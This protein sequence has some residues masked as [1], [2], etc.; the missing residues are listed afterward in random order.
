MTYQWPHINVGEKHGKDI[1][2]AVKQIG[3]GTHVTW[4]G[5]SQEGTSMSWSF[6]FKGS[7]NSNS[8]RNNKPPTW[9]LGHSKCHFYPKK[10]GFGGSFQ[11]L[12]VVVV[13]HNPVIK[14]ENPGIRDFFTSVISCDSWDDPRSN[15]LMVPS[16]SNAQWNPWR[17]PWGKRT[18]RCGTLTQGF[19]REMIDIHGGFSTSKPLHQGTH[20][21]WL[22]LETMVETGWNPGSQKIA[23]RFLHFHCQ[24]QKHPKM[25]HPLL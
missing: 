23:G 17:V 6:F 9:T 5:Q 1:N 8:A 21:C 11:L 18:K 20:W 22:M 2:F 19:P 10:F 15:F 14:W 13:G 24:I 25:T 7:L 4:Y 16:A 3:F 12:V